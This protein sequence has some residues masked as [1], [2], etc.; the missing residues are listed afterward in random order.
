MLRIGIPRAFYYYKF[1]NLWPRF[2]FYAGA[3]PVISPPT[4]KLI[5]NAGINMS[6][7]E[8]CLPFKVY[9]G[10]MQALQ[11]ECDVIFVPRLVSIEKRCYTCPKVLG[12]PDIVRLIFP[13]EKLFM[14]I[15]NQYN[16]H[17]PEEFLNETAHL[18]NISKRKIWQAWEKA[19]K[20][21]HMEFSAELLPADF[22]G[23]TKVSSKNYFKGKLALLGHSY[24][25]YDSFTTMNLIDKIRTLGFQ[26]ITSETIPK[27]DIKK[28]AEMLPKH[29]F[30]SMGKELLG[31]AKL[32]LRNK[33]VDGIIYL[34]CFGCGADALIAELVMRY[35]ARKGDTPF[36]ML[37][38]DEHSGEAGLITRV[39]AFTDMLTRRK[40]SG[41]N[42]FSAYGN[43]QYSREG[44]V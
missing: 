1:F 31:A 39:E 5:V 38:I 21:A 37:N 36:L 19:S 30:W 15:I 14:P 11:N 43:T 20:D 2:F 33:T 12:L 41:E 44:I 7:D 25:I 18:L 3:E 6:V 4:N 17:E 28:E 23:Q 34:A 8:M 40:A 24:N 16:G 42:N 35:S 27:E 10:H 22:L 32:L 29:M 26:V 13:E 9:L